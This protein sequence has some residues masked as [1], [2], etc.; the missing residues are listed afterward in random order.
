M[1]DLGSTDG[2][3]EALEAVGA[4]VTR[5]SVQ[6]FRFDTARNIALSLLPPDC[7]LCVSLDLSDELQPGWAQELQAEWG[8][9]SGT[10]TEVRV[11]YVWQFAADGASLAQHE[12]TAIH[13]RSGYRWDGPAHEALQWT[14]RGGAGKAVPTALPHLA[15]HSKAGKATDCWRHVCR[16][17]YLSLLSLGAKEDPASPRRSYYCECS[18]ALFLCAHPCMYSTQTCMRVPPTAGDMSGCSQHARLHA[19]PPV[20]QLRLPS[21]PLPVQTVVRCTT[22]GLMRKG[23]WSW[24]ATWRW[25]EAPTRSSAQ[26]HCSTLLGATRRW[27]G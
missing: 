17:P 23:L 10:V 8:R 16:H 12:V 22:W 3:A 21:P 11:T 7:D 14:G 25:K 5:V 20:Q 1:A 2:T 9:S 15:L 4:N 26:R 13:A 24:S 19:L 6:P 27:G 18:A